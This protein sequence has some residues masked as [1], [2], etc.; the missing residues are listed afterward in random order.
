[1]LTEAAK[2]HSIY[3]QVLLDLDKVVFQQHLVVVIRSDIVK[4]K[5]MLGA[6]LVMA[7]IR[8]NQ[9]FLSLLNNFVN[10][11]RLIPHDAQLLMVSNRGR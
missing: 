11:S 8:F 4:N 7:G 2:I 5:I 3:C 10:L 6:W 1:M 9:G